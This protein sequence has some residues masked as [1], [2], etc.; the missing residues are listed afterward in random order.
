MRM[1]NVPTEYLCR[2]HLLGE[3]VEMHMFIGTIDKGISIK[4]YVDGGLVETQLISHRHDELVRE[5]KK[6][7]YNHNSPVNGWKC[8]MVLGNVDVTNSINELNK[9]CIECKDNIDKIL[10]KELKLLL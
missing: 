2:K 5:M 1:W 4:G 6:R 9:R 3:H 10:N 7:G 8:D